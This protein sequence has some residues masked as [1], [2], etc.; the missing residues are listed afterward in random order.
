MPERGEFLK[1]GCVRNNEVTALGKDPE[2]GA[3]N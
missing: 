1:R 2:D 3:E